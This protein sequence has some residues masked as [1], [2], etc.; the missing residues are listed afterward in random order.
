M[1]WQTLGSGGEQTLQAKV[2]KRIDVT[3]ILFTET[4]A[5]RKCQYLASTEFHKLTLLFE[6]G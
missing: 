5:T 4:D 1:F 2:S 3:F 6:M